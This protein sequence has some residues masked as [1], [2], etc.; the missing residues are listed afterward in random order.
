MFCLFDI[1][2]DLGLLSG[3]WGAWAPKPK[4]KEH[5]DGV[6]G[7]DCKRNGRQNKEAEG[8]KRTPSLSCLVSITEC[9]R[10]ALRGVQ[11]WVLAL[12]LLGGVRCHLSLGSRFLHLQISRLVNAQGTFHPG[13]LS[14]GLTRNH[15]LCFFHS[16]CL[17]G[18][19]SIFGSKIWPRWIAFHY[20]L[21]S[22]FPYS[23]IPSLLFHSSLIAFPSF[24]SVQLAF[25]S[26][27]RAYVRPYRYSNGW[28]KAPH[29]VCHL[30]G[31]WWC[32]MIKEN[33]GCCRS[34]MKGS[35]NSAKR[36]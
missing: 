7:R 23:F 1:K 16:H 27:A 30:M 9:L 26:H 33:R 14:T 6:K 8:G 28:V 11:A 24:F 10:W 34:I 5:R 4:S 2:I 3:M 31:A 21:T 35:L 22:L 25:L 29:G 32:A 18:K 12:D 13:P 36:A 15:V 17:R 19:M 20:K